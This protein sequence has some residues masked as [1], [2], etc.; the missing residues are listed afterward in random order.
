MSNFKNKAIDKD[1]SSG[2]VIL[3]ATACGIIV[4]NLYYAQPLIGVI[5]N[6]I[7]LSNSSAGLIVT[8]TQIGYVVGLLFLVPL[9]DIV[10]NKKLI[11]I[12]LFL[13]AFALICMV[14]V[15]SATLL[16]I[17]SFF[18]GLG[19][20]A[21]QVLV[22][23]VSYLSS[24][25]ARGRVVGNVMS[26]LLLGIMLARPISSLVADMWGWGTIFALSATVII[27]LAFVLS[28]VL[29]TRKP[30][31]KTN[32]IA[33]LNSM[34]QL[35]RTT[36]V[37]RR[38]AMYHACVFGAFSLFW[39][40]VPLLLS[41][42]AFHFSQTAIALYALVG[43]TGAI[44]APIGGRLADL[45]W[46][47]PATGIALTVVIISLILPLF[48]Q[49]SSPFGIAV[50]VIAAILLDMGVS[51]N[52]VLSQRLIFSLSPEIR[53]RLNG[54]F[55]AIFFLGGA[56]GSFIGGWAYAL[57]G[58]NLTLWIGIAFPTIALLYFASEK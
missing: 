5:S 1:I 8:L 46:T 12:L 16:L 18:I 14:F 50:L 19:S 51:A 43:I 40:T 45:G 11:L 36:P 13:S 9:G 39:T 47:R 34:W 54:L 37:L 22:P 2:L 27:V 15:K 29:P 58:W 38:R 42:P 41:S 57:G 56:V 4:A 7:G 3:L 24:E 20:V 23:L 17:T 48:I 31:A 55:M 44:A 52:L 32:Y 33:L 26:G 25:N 49:S 30:Q 35:L 6:E 21:A 28:K 10:E 53:S